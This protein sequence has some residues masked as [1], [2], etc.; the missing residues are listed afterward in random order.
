[1]A[2]KLYYE[3]SYGNKSEVSS[4]TDFSNPIT[5]THDGKNGDLKSVCLYI[6][7]DNTSLWY[8]NIEILPVDLV[9]ASPYGDVSYDETGWG[10]KLNEGGTEPTPSEWNDIDWG[11]K[12]P[13]EDIGSSLGAD[14]T[15]YFPF[16]YLVTCPPNTDVQNKSDIILRVSY[17]E[18]AVV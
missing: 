10:V 16:W 15:T 2:L 9:D 6:K 1:M 18:N 7:N 5:T 11:K 17:T 14:T 3:D 13:I 8:S 12:L 4:G